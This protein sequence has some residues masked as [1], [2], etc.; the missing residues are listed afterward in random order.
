ML[1]EKVFKIA[2]AYEIL[3]TYQKTK[4]LFITVGRYQSGHNMWLAAAEIPVSKYFFSVLASPKSALIL[5][6]ESY[7]D[8]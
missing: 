5:G 7:T 3:P 1:L 4:D 2:K 6:L 8:I